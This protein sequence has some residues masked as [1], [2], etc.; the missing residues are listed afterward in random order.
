MIPK[1]TNY[2]AKM[3][4]KIRSLPDS[5]IAPRLSKI[6]LRKQ[7]HILQYPGNGRAAQSLDLS[8]RSY[9]PKR[10][11]VSREC[12]AAKATR[13]ELDVAIQNARSLYA[14][15]PQALQQVRVSSSWF[16]VTLADE[17]LC[18][19]HR[20]LMQKKI[21]EQNLISYNCPAS[22]DLIICVQVNAAIEMWGGIP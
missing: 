4:G 16:M 17:Q 15:L 20:V 3:P 9:L 19:S 12:T 18:G 8:G 5:R 10:V 21:R 13:D 11:K 1:E 14:S 6:E 22:P 7:T 2:Q